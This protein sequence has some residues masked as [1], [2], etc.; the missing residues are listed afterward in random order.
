VRV[1]VRHVVPPFRNSGTSAFHVRKCTFV[2]LATGGSLFLVIDLIL[3]DRSQV[4]DIHPRHTF[5]L[6]PEKQQRSRSEPDL[7]NGT[8]SDF[9][10]ERCT[11][12]YRVFELAFYL[13]D[14]SQAP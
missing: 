2:S 3:M 13:F 7:L 8:S 14:S 5:L 4:H 1:S 6:V 10:E 12:L 11:Y 9:N